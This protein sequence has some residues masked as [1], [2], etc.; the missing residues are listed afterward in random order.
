ME[1]SS[2]RFAKI[3]GQ[4]GSSNGPTR[5]MAAKRASEM[6]SAANKTWDDV[7]KAFA[8]HRPARAP[9]RFEDTVDIFNM[10]TPK[11]APKPAN[12]E[13]FSGSEV[14]SMVRGSVKIL[15][16][17][18][19]KKGVKM[20]TVMIENET[21]H[22]GPLVVFDQTLQEHLRQNPAPRMYPVSP[23]V[24]MMMPVLKP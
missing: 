10:R 13:I 21:A 24:G 9:A 11:P 6:L 8:G 18:L 7:A 2:E 5:E 4:L 14:P 1:W 12:Y 15:D 17:R 3:L 19:T 23:S 20:M 22:Y 16:D